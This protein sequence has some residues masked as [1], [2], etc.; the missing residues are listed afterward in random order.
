[1]SSNSINLEISSHILILGMG[2]TI[3][4]IAPKPEENPLHYQAGQVGVDALV[5]HIQSAVTCQMLTSRH[6][7]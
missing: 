1:M 5:S 4:G 7:G 2:G 6:W 3:A